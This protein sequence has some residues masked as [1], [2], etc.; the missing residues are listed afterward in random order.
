MEFLIGL[1]VLFIIIQVIRGLASGAK[2]T[3]KPEYE[4]SVQVSDS[5]GDG[6]ASSNARPKGKPAKWY[7]KGQSITVKGH[8][9]SSGLIYVGGNLPDSYGYQNDACLINPNLKVASANP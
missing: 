2:P 5:R 3:R 8:E 6:Y 1:F 9:L 7:G 4:I